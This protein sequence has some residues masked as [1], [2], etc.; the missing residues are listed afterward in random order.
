MLTITLA[1]LLLIAILLL[2]RIATVSSRRADKIAYLRSRASLYEERVYRVTFA[3][4]RQR[5]F[6]IKPHD[7]PESYAVYMRVDDDHTPAKDNP[8]YC[9]LK[10]FPWDDD[11]DFALREAR[12][13]VD[14]LNAK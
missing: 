2:W 9:I 8:V 4:P 11:R 12:E 6:I 13:L 14:H 1:A 10:V 3:S 7:C 5:S